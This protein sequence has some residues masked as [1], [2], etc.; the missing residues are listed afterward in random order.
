MSQDYVNV[1][2]DGKEYTFNVDGIMD[3]RSFNGQYSYKIKCISSSPAPSSLRVGS[4]Y[5][6]S[7]SFFGWKHEGKLKYSGSVY[8]RVTGL[9][10]LYFEGTGIRSVDVK[11]PKEDY[12]NELAQMGGWMDF[13]H[14]KRNADEVDRFAKLLFNELCKREGF[15]GPF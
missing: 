15:E 5:N 12:C 4:E 8:F 13:D 6:V 2:V 11:M 1:K 9:Y 10:T 3:E 7:V 14:L